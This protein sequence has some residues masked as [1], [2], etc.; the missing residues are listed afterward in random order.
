MGYTLI[1]H[2]QNSEPIVGE[3]DELPAKADTLVQLRNPRKQDGRDLHYLAENS[4]MVF[5][6]VGNLNFIE[7]VAS[8]ADEE[9]IA[10]VRE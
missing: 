6:P 8:P 1:L 9:V 2:I 4:I 5:W 3:C 10:F 7:V